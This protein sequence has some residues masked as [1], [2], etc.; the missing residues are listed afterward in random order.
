LVRRL[1]RRQ[2]SLEAI[3]QHLPS[4]MRNACARL[5]LT[6]KT[7]CRRVVA[8]MWFLRNTVSTTDAI[9]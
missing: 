2:E 8:D 4:R 6:N 1:G 7:F 3:A 9:G 5:L